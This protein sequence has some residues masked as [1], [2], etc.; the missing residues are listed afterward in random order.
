MTRLANYLETVDVRD[1]Q[2]VGT[3]AFRNEELTLPDGSKL[4]LGADSGHWVMVFQEQPGAA[5]EIIE[6]DQHSGKVFV[7]K[8]PGGPAELKRFK[9]RLRYFFAH[10]RVADLVTIVP[11]QTEEK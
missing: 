10:A 8:K 7:D 5:F 1:R 2:F 4:A 6:Y 3:I 11:P 9:Q